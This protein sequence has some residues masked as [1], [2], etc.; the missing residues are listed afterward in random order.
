MTLD[1]LQLETAEK[2]QNLPMNL[3][4]YWWK[5]PSTLPFLLFFLLYFIREK[6]VP[7]LGEGSIFKAFQNFHP[8]PWPTRVGTRPQVWKALHP[9]Q[10]K[11]VQDEAMQAVL[12]MNPNTSSRAFFIFLFTCLG[13]FSPLLCPKFTRPTD[14]PPPT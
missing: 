4:G 8:S 13:F 1:N 6:N 2:P 14:L 11:P 10:S 9:G 5:L 7:Y 12:G 3:R